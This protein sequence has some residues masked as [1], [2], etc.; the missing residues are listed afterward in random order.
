VGGCYFLSVVYILW[1]STLSKASREVEA[2]VQVIEVCLVFP[3]TGEFPFTRDS[4]FV[5]DREEQ[6]I[7]YLD[8]M[9]LKEQLFFG[10]QCFKSHE[11]F[12]SDKITM[13]MRETRYSHNLHYY[14]LY[15][16]TSYSVLCAIQYDLKNHTQICA[17]LGT[18]VVWLVVPGHI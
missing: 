9:L 1:A 16:N 3:H 7:A 10:V 13:R 12:F 11:I 5:V 2:G 17:V 15:E 8:W 18:G 4:L 6:R 14:E